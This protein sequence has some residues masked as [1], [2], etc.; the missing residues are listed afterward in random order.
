[1]SLDVSH[2]GMKGISKFWY[3]YCNICQ[4]SILL[5]KHD[6]QHEYPKVQ[7]S[8]D[9]WDMLNISSELLNIVGCIMSDTKKQKDWYIELNS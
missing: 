7:H 2:E 1:M 9:N 4:K 5:R 6:E 3:T 8:I